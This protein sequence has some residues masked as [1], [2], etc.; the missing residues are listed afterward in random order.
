MMQGFPRHKIFRMSLGIF[1]QACQA[2]D[3]Y[4]STWLGGNL[5]SQI[6]TNIFSALIVALA[7][8]TLFELWKH[9]QELSSDEL[10]EDARLLVWKVGIFMLFPLLVWLDL[11]ATIVATEQLGGFIKDWSYGIVWFNAIPQ[12]LPH[13]DY[14]MPALFAG[15]AVQFLL[16]ICL[17]PALFFRPHPFLA[18]LISY[19]V[20]IICASTLMID[21][22]LGL[23]GMGGSRWQLAYSSLPKDTLMIILSMYLCMCALFILAIKSKTIRI[24]FAEITNPVLAEQLR[25]A[26]LEA[27]SDRKNQFQSCRLGILLEKAGMRRHASREFAHLKEIAPTSL[28]VLFLDGFMQYRRRN[29]RKA[30]QAFEQASN[31]PFLTENLK[32]TFLSAAACS[33]FAQGDT[34]GS[35]NLCERALEFDDA[36]LVARMVKVDAFLRL[37]KKEQAGE[38]VLTALKQGLDFEIEDKV[39]LDA[40]LTL[41]QI[42]RFQRQQANERK[43]KEQAQQL[44]RF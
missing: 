32:G 39:P 41:K 13:A 6:C 36:A 17:I 35:I 8:S 33:A 25:I 2:G 16:A 11:K 12:G 7:A 21:P 1:S 34:H 10:S 24:W 30:R 3:T 4:N 27:Q 5:M 37:G 26:M 28:F 43:S 15:V 9:R 14:L 42:V 22:M 29:Y 40:E 19:T 18:T 20:A 31:Y 23:L 38:E 44:V